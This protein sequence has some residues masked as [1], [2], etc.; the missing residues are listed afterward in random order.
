MIR[1]RG[2]T[3]DLHDAYAFPPCGRDC[4][5][6]GGRSGAP[7]G[8]GERRPVPDELR[9][10]QSDSTERQRRLVVVH[11]SARHRGRWEVDCG[12]GARHRR[13]GGEHQR[14]TLG[15]RRNRGLR[16]PDGQ[17]RHDGSASAFSAGRSQRPGIS[18]AARRPLPGDLHETCD[19]AK[20]VFPDLGTAQSPRL[21]A[22]VDP[23]DARQRR[24]LRG[25][26]RHLFESVPD[27]RRP[28]LQ[29]LPRLQSRSELH[30]VGR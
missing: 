14:S 8:A 23:R 30:D 29:L 7:A 9:R 27:A 15:Q 6:R 11:G 10:R 13:R 18:G 16:H 20:G 24:G 21:G 28:H 1:V 19:R 4:R 17:S 22:R 26:Q 2:D 12:I 3:I 25:R 5:M